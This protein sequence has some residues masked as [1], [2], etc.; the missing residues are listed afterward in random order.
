MFSSILWIK[1]DFLLFYSRF[2]FDSLVQCT[3]KH[4]V[5]SCGKRSNA[6]SIVEILYFNVFYIKLISS[7]I[8]FV[9]I[10]CIC[11]R[12]FQDIVNSNFSHFHGYL[13]TVSL[14]EEMA[15][16]C[17]NFTENRDLLAKKITG[18]PEMA[19][20]M[21]DRNL[22]TEDDRF[23]IMSFNKK[24]RVQK[25]L[26]IVESKYCFKEFI[27]MLKGCRLEECAKLIQG[28]YGT[29][30]LFRI[31]FYS[32]AYHLFCLSPSKFSIFHDCV[33]GGNTAAARLLYKNARGYKQIYRCNTRKLLSCFRLSFN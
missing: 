25:L 14:S 32:W 3:V 1:Y 10:E 13:E 5:N 9:D 29:C 2:Y 30:S 8:S 28:K 16:Y 31:L 27:R 17:Q 20:K 21:E 26:E 11:N 4:F 19:K 6:I 12:I 23:K 15:K 33:K 24:G 18:I 7:V 22:I